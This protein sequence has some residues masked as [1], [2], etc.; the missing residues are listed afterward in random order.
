MSGKSAESRKTYILG[1]KDASWCLIQAVDDH[2]SA[3]LQ[4]EYEQSM[5]RSVP[6]AAARDSCSLLFTL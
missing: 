4:A 3:L 1:E 5:S 2:D 6:C